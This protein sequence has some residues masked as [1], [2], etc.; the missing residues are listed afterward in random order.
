MKT[1]GYSSP[2]FSA[3]LDSESLD[4][5]VELNDFDEDQ[6]LMNDD[7][8]PEPS[9]SKQIVPYNNREQIDVPKVDDSGASSSTNK[10]DESSQ[11][12]MVLFNRNFERKGVVKRQPKYMPGFSTNQ[13]VKSSDAVYTTH[14]HRGRRGR[15]EF[16][17]FFLHIIKDSF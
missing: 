12:Q 15:Y 8:E 10:E 2:C 1:S 11:Q 5:E 17:I 9:T 6:L 3:P 13:M 7:D 4:Y 14:Y 16:C